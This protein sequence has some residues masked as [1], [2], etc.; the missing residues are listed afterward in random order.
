M[1]DEISERPLASPLPFF[2]SLSVHVYILLWG[3]W[4]RIWV[5]RDKDIRVG[6]ESWQP[7]LRSD[8]TALSLHVL[9]KVLFQTSPACECQCLVDC[10]CYSRHFEWQS[11]FLAHK[12][13]QW[14]I[15]SLA[16]AGYLH[17][18]GPV[19]LGTKYKMH[20]P[21]RLQDR[22]EKSFVS[23]VALMKGGNT[24][25]AVNAVPSDHISLQ[26]YH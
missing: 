3:C 26:K 24:E 9:W 23:T 18:A 2:L 15:L 4:C 5:G 21:F 19:A 16:V 14:K 22:W 13:A 1:T 11:G 12:R 10:S 20:I 17:S 7:I 8:F 6:W 25:L